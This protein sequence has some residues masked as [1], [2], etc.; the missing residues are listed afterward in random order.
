MA[1]PNR[2]AGVASVTID[3]RAYSI[4]GEGTYRTSSPTRETLKG[5][6]GVHGYS[7]MPGAGKI[8]WKGRDS[9]AVSMGALNAASNVTVVLSL[10]NGKIVIGRNMWRTGEPAEVNT[11]DGT[12][13]IE[14]ESDDVT[15]A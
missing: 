7:E 2:I 3:G 12:F 9:G 14:F 4:A 13:S 15:E 6:D 5:Q 10:A 11:E 8:S 1:D